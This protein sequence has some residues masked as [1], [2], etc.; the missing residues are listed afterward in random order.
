MIALGPESLDFLSRH[1]DS[2]FPG[3]PVVFSGVRG[4]V[5]PRLPAQTTGVVTHFDPIET[6]ELALRELAER[7]RNVVETQTALN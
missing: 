3:V 2:L 7:T 4:P 1:R 6:L 5:V